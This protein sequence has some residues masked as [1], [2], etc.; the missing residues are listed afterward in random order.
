MKVHRLKVLTALV[1]ST[2]KR[3]TLQAGCS[4]E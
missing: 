3:G 4:N 1:F 2:N